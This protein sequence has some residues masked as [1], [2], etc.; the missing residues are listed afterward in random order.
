MGKASSLIL[1]RS[2]TDIG[3]SSKTSELFIMK[4]WRTV[5]NV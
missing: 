5:A 1:M 2:S 3:S 4:I